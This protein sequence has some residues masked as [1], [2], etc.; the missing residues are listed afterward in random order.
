M[1]SRLLP[2]LAV[3]LCL[4]GGCADGSGRR[5]VGDAVSEEEA[6]L[7]AGLLER[8]HDQGGADFVVT[9]PYAPGAVLTLTGEVDFRS[10]AGRAKAVTS[11]QEGETVC[12]VFFTRDELWFGDLPGT[13]PGA[14]PVYLHRPVALDGE[15]G[16]PLVDVLVTVLLGLSADSADTPAAF[17]DG[18][19]RWQGRRSIDGRPTALYGLPDG[20]TVAVSSLDDLLVQ[21]T[22]ALPSGPGSPPLEVTTTLADHGPRSLE[23]PAEAESAPAADHPDLAAALGL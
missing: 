3:A 8:N 4:V 17:L 2:A 12:R 11:T 18:D 9:A 10:G 19:Y 5:T 23:L 14:E 13:T 20:R 16:P 1:R 21:F 7:L 15:A 22:A 6:T